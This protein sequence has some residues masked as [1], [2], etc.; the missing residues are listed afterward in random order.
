[1]N[2]VLLVGRIVRPIDVQLIG[3]SYR[4]VNN[5]LAVQRNQRDKNGET[6]TDFIPFV[7]WNRLADLLDK[8]G[9]KGQRVAISGAMQSRNYTNNS[10]QAVYVIECVVEEITLLDRPQAKTKASHSTASTAVPSH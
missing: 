3:E 1:M 8:H 2:Q 10:Q 5:T 7:A 6:I 9:Q 4:V